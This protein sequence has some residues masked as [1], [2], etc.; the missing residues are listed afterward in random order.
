[1]QIS[2]S[3]LEVLRNHYDKQKQLRESLNLKL[4]DDDYVFCIPPDWKPCEP[5]TIGRAWNRV[6]KKAGIKDVRFH[7][8]RHT[9][10]SMLLKNN[11]HPKIVSE[12]LGHSSIGIT[13][14]LYSHVSPTLQQEAVSKLD[15]LVFGES[16]R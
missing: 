3:T 6:A 8:L 4:T 10:A 1:M 2:E 7:D 16:I 14:D 11:V 12:M 5:S 15:N 9:F 13:M